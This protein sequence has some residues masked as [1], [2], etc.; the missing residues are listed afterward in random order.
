MIN[1]I[2]LTSS[3]AA[4]A[5]FKFVVKHDQRLQ[6]FLKFWCN[7]NVW[8]F[9]I[10]FNDPNWQLKSDLTGL[11]RHSEKT[12][13]FGGWRAPGS[14]NCWCIWCVR[15]CSFSRSPVGQRQSSQAAMSSLLSK[16][17]T[18]RSYDFVDFAHTGI[19]H[20]LSFLRLHWNMSV[21]DQWHLHW[22]CARS[23][24]SMGPPDLSN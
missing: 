7:L 3:H 8:T 22:H 2:S 24:W 9:I 5:S 17:C 18:S 20:C 14:W 23:S 16:L 10:N 6:W 19:F 4:H 11:N 21:D 1:K 15:A 12:Y 13:S